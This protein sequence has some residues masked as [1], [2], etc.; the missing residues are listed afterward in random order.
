ME[1]STVERRQQRRQQLQQQPQQST[2]LPPPAGTQSA[3]ESPRKLWQARADAQAR[4][5]SGKL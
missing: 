3:R 1:N 2:L 4:K 5:Q